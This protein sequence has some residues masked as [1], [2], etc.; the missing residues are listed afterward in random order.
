VEPK[1]ESIPEI[2]ARVSQAVRDWTNKSIPPEYFKDEAVKEKF[3]KDKTREAL[4]KELVP[5]IQEAQSNRLRREFAPQDGRVKSLGLN[6]KIDKE[7]TDAI[8]NGLDV[9]RKQSADANGKIDTLMR[10]LEKNPIGLI[11]RDTTVKA[12]D[13]IVSG[14]VSGLASV[15]SGLRGGPNPSAIIN[16]VKT[17]GLNKAGAY[18]MMD[19]QIVVMTGDRTQNQP[20]ISAAAATRNLKQAKAAAAANWRWS[21]GAGATYLHEVG[22]VM[23]ARAFAGKNQREIEKETAIQ[24]KALGIKSVSQY[25]RTNALETTAELYAAYVMNG[26]QLKKAMPEAYQW[27]DTLAKNAYNRTQ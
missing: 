14:K 21:D 7:G 1:R 23:H 9:I 3:I 22:H 24:L 17:Y 19:S 20:K 16:T 25:G 15:T 11:G 12:E 2:H 6:G 10:A 5:K 13:S 4:K 18:A 27:I 26:P 8:N